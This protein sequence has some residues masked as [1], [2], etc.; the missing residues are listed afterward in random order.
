M[1]LFLIRWMNLL[2]FFNEMRHILRKEYLHNILNIIF[3]LFRDLLKTFH[4][5]LRRLVNI[6]NGKVIRMRVTDGI[7]VWW[8]G[9]LWILLFAVMSIWL[10]WLDC[11]VPAQEEIVIGVIGVLALLMLMLI[12]ITQDVIWP[13]DPPL[14][15]L[16]WQYTLLVRLYR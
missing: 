6:R 2:S 9:E 4:Q 14:L 5:S 13:I 8:H 11:V 12:L 10:K 15:R 1:S 3:A 16:A 7:L